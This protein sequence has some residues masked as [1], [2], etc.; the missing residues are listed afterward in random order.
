MIF[1]GG[2]AVSKATLQKLYIYILYFLA[3]IYTRLY[4]ITLYI[5]YSLS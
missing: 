2:N 4:C 5:I 1:R 3:R